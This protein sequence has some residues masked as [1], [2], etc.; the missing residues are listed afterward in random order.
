[1]LKFKSTKKVIEQIHSEFD[2]ASERLLREAKTIL[3]KPLEDEKANKLEKLG[4]RSASAV[5]KAD[6][7]RT[8][9][10]QNSEV[11]KLVEYYNIHYPNNKF[12]T[13][14]IVKEIC[15]KYNLVCATVDRY[16]GDVPMKNV[17]EMERFVLRQEDK[18]KNSRWED[19]I[20]YE[21]FGMINQFSGGLGLLGGI[22]QYQPKLPTAEEINRMKSEVYYTTPSF[23]IC[24]PEKDFNTYGM[25]KMGHKLIPDPIVLQPVSGGYLI[26][27]KWGLEG[28]DPALLNEK[29]N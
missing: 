13:A 29:H 8:L 26:V 6:A 3:S 4:F 23:E 25:T 17:L 10:K 19:H 1:M 15:K 28:D 9:A 24:A 21:R 2:S 27:T 18:K 20:R 5:K 7:H 12:I 22:P 11:M 14:E 16:I